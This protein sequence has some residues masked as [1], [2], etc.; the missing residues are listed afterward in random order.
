MNRLLPLYL[1]IKENCSFYLVSLADIQQKEVQEAESYVDEVS[2]ERASR[3]AFEKDRNKLIIVQATLRFLLGK[4]LGK[5][6]MEM[7][8]LRDDF[9]KPFIKDN[10]VHFSLAYSDTYAFMGFSPVNSIG[11][12]IEAIN[13]ERVVIDSPVLHD[14]EK[15]V[16]RGAKDTID[17]F[18]EYWCAKEALLKALGTGFTEEKPPLLEQV[19]NGVFQS[20]DPSYIIYTHSTHDHKVGVCLLHSE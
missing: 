7:I 13:K 6:P 2:L 19:S 10:L 14:S 5:T 8:I 4:F 18:Y 20:E 11:V 3:Y 1:P 9:G 16:I 12:D 15:E 17:A